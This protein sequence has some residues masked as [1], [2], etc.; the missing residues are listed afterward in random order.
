MK[1]DFIPVL[2]ENLIWF[3]LV[4]V[5]L[6]FALQ[7]PFFLTSVNITNILSAAAVL[8]I[9][10]VGQT[11]VLITGN[12]DLSS[13][14]TLGL[15]ALFGIWHLHEWT[16]SAFDDLSDDVSTLDQSPEGFAEVASRRA[17]RSGS[18]SS[19]RRTSGTPRP[20]PR[21]CNSRATSK[22]SPSG[23]GASS[24]TRSGS[25]SPSAISASRAERA[26]RTS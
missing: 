23:C 11:F 9:L 16:L 18:G 8:G 22:P 17:A 24:R 5:F 12:F 7:S 10:V 4:A 21:R 25:R 26:T 19:V 15:S 3:I 2:L 6:F 20:R 13:E 1:R 14:S